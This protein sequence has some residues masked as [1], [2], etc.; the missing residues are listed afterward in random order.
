MIA[1]CGIQRI[2]FEEEYA[3]P[4]SIGLLTTAGVELW[5]WDK[6]THTA[7]PYE[8]LN[9]FEEAQDRLREKW[10]QGPDLVR[11]G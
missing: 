6:K 11:R 7:R 9:T 8:P 5:I 1:N 3:D 2:I 10:A 4:L